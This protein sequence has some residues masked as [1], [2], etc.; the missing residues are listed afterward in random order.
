M[1]GTFFFFKA[2]LYSLAYYY[3]THLIMDYLHGVNSI[4]MLTMY[5]CYEVLLFYA[6]KSRTIIMNKICLP[7]RSNDLLI[8]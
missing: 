3:E 2:I 7:F 1:V 6:N 5:R 4:F 8:L